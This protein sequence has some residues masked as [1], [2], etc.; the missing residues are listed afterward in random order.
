MLT[1]TT[2]AWFTTNRIV[3]VSN[4]DVK[5]QAEGSLEISVDAVNFK[6]GVTADEIIGHSS[7]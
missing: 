6:P 7:W 1:T 4:I 5:V 3:T 2:Y